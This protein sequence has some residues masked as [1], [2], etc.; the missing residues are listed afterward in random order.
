[1]EK[2][3]RNWDEYRA[4]SLREV[5]SYPLEV[6]YIY[7]YWTKKKKLISYYWPEK[8]SLKIMFS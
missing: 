7:P 6:D 2:K 1:M 4:L 8:K 3:L 5:K